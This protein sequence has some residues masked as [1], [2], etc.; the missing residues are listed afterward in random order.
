M[1]RFLGWLWQDLRFAVRGLNKDRR[2]TLLAI[3]ALAL[4]IGSVT[5]MFSAIYGVLIDTFPYAHFDRMVSFSIDDLGQQGYNRESL[6]IPEFL[7]L[8]EQNHV[9]E[10]MEGGTV[11]P[12]F[13]YTDD[14]H[15]TRQWTI[16]CESATGYQFLGV[17]P[18]LGR[19]ITAED[20][21]P[22]ATPA[23]MMTYK[24]WKE[25]FNG[26]PNILGKEFNLSGV[27]WKLVGIMPARFRPGW[28]DVFTAFPNDRARI[29]ED[30]A[31]KNATVWPL[32]F[33]KPNVTVQQAAADLDVVVHNLAKVYPGRYPKQFRV[34][35]RSFQARV[36][37]MFEP[38]LYP[39]L[40][41]VA[42]LLLIACTNVANLLLSR[43][44]VRDREIA[45]RASLGASRWRLIRQLL[46]ESFVLAAAGCLAG[47]F[48]A[49]L[50]IKELVP[51]IPYDNFPQES[52]VELNWIVLL[53]SMGLAMFATILCGL[54]P[55]IHAVGGP[56]HP[57]LA[58]S[59]MG[60][61]AGLRHGKLR[62]ALVVIEVAL[63]I[64]L[65][66]GAG[67][68]MRTF[69]SMTGVDLGY[70]PRNILAVRLD[71]P[72]GP[73]DKGPQRKLFF[74]QV[75]ARVRMLPGVIAA[76]N[77]MAPD[78]SDGFRSNVTLPGAP[79]SDKQFVTGNLVG[80][81]YF[82]V[83]GY[84]LLR[85]RVL[86]ADDIASAQHVI[87]VNQAFV[88]KFFPNND[89]I[90]RQVDFDTLDPV[91]SAPDPFASEETSAR[92]SPAPK[93]YFDIVGVVSD[94]KDSGTETA[95]RQAAMFPCTILEPAVSG[96]V[97]STIGG[98]DT[99]LPAVT[100]QVWAVDPS[101]RLGQD[102][103]SIENTLQ[104]YVYAEPEFEFVMI[105][106]FA[107]VGLLLV[108]IGVYSVMSYNV[109][110]QTH[111]IGIRMALGAQQSDVLRMVVR[112]GLTLIVLGVIT[113]AF[114]S[115][116]LT[117][118]I[119]AMLWGVKPTDP[120]TFAV[121]IVIILTVG[122]A[123]CLVPA[124]RATKVD[125]LVALRYE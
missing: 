72:R 2:F 112:K 113:G 83:F 35:A 8:R 22:G 45:V 122:L 87:V 60:A 13:L 50:G 106:T 79:R 120:L 19:L 74:D 108:I 82:K 97:I 69:F 12:A 47:C 3:L 34:T 40:G 21:E 49:Y 14:N 1:T 86:T 75:L 115:W 54:A 59:G 53:A 48:F 84:H 15:Q 91:L 20:T 58:G 18:V 100:Q 77:V 88:T 41:A 90:G 70:N 78:A 4:G 65:L 95:P 64:V 110:L 10:D 55:A 52:V 61:S 63:S 24:V 43:A 102:S 33:L 44:T 36:V 116:G 25:Q 62:A 121:V 66:V 6:S 89:P 125:P 111:E 51:L 114:A 85:G 32:G 57:R 71:L 117:R 16:T 123:A 30:P 118:L 103:G 105:S 28:N 92:N 124:R 107:A 26:D 94:A 119:R 104:K 37:I 5:V 67:L 7:D 29:A 101:I 42:L 9:F 76:A 39:L 93:V 73:Y 80:E 11:P 23:F 31:L 98:A 27:L 68:M 38:I 17:K 96:I 81:D 109:S 46:V 99:M 56:L